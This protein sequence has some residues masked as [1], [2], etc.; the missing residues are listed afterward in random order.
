VVHH[1]PI[2]QE[3][4]GDLEGRNSV[5]IAG[6]GRKE[7][8]PEAKV[9]VGD[10]KEELAVDAAEEVGLEVEDASRSVRNNGSANYPLS[11]SK[12]AI[13]L[14]CKIRRKATEIS[15][16]FCALGEYTE[17]TSGIFHHIK[18]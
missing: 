2:H 7:E 10:Q 5:D 9:L 1:D 12:I 6:D 17:L 13:Y 15:T 14:A 16:R 4:L 8:R 11:S 3:G 18:A